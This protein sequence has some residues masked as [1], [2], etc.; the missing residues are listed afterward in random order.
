[1]RL[2]EKGVPG[3]DKTHFN[4]PSDMLFM[5]TAVLRDRRLSERAS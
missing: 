4:Q 5:P 1:M 3:N 2:G